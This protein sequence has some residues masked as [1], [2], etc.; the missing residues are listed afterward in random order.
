MIVRQRLTASE[1]QVYEWLLEGVLGIEIA[2]R[3]NCTS[4]A[5][6]KI[7]RRIIAKGYSLRTLD[8]ARAATDPTVL[9]ELLGH[10]Y[11]RKAEVERYI[12]LLE[13]AQPQEAA[14]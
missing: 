13:G 7:K 2:R 4:A 12:A 3:R 11:A 9:A 8:E 6:S 5:V 10:L 14:E 1:Q